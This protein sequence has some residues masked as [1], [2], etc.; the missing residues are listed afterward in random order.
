MGAP[1]ALLPIGGETLVERVVGRVIRACSPVVVV[2]QASLSLPSFGLGVR[3]VRDPI[4][5]GGP[6]VGLV[7]GLEALDDAAWAFVCAVDAPFVA[8]SVIARLRALATDEVDAV[9]PRLDGDTYPLTALYARRVVP[10]ARGLLD[11][12]ERR[13]RRLAETSRTRFVDRGDLLADGDVAAEDPAL[14]TFHNVNTPGDW[15]RALAASEARGP[16]PR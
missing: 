12:G 5:D 10:A 3:V 13:A 1:K 15:E 4:A 14:A 11:A 8:P 6:L 2:A 9:V 7:A 16:K